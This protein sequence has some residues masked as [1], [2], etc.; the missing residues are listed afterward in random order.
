MFRVILFLIV[1]CFT[2]FI[3][4]QNVAVSGALVG[5]G[6][7]PTLT[8]AFAALNGGA[9]TGATITVSILANT[10]EGSGTAVLNAGAWT[11]ITVVPVGGPR[12]ITGA[13]A[14]G[15]PLIDLNGADR[16]T[17][18]GQLAGGVR[19]LT[20]ENTTVA[21]STGTSTVRLRNDATLNT[22]T[23]CNVLGGS[24]GAGATIYFAAG[25][26]TVGNDNN[27]I[28]LCDIG[29][30]GANLPRTAIFSLGDPS[31]AN[32]NNLVTQ[33][34]I[35]DYFQCGTSSTG[36]SLGE[37]NLAWTISQCRFY[38]TAPRVCSLFVW[39]RGILIDGSQGNADHTIT[40]NTFGYANSLGTGKSVF[41]SSSTSNAGNFYR[42]IDVPSMQ[43][44]SFLTVTNNVVA[45]L[46]FPNMNGNDRVFS[47]AGIKVRGAITIT[48]NTIGSSSVPGTISMGSLGGNGTVIGIDV[49]I[50]GVNS[51]GAAVHNNVV[52]GINL[53]V[54]TSST[55]SFSAI[56]TYGN[57]PIFYCN[58][59]S[60]QIGF[61]AAPIVVNS[62]SPGS[63]VRGI[64]MYGYDIDV[65]DN[66]VCYLFSRSVYSEGLIGLDIRANGLGNWLNRNVVFALETTHPT[67]I[68]R[69]IGILA[70]NMEFTDRNH[71]HSLSAASPNGNIWGMYVRAL[72]SCTYSNNM[73]RLG[74]NHQGQS[75]Q[76]GIR[77]IGIYDNFGNNDFYYNSVH[78]G[79]DN[80][81]GS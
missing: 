35:Y 49:E 80:V 2:P 3:H 28:S 45:G 64:E 66:R 14:P 73:V 12:S 60:N 8:A 72:D 23:Y 26:V 55:V 63:L 51:I 76:N 16:V 78:I 21:N 1:L 17:F 62:A 77:I 40:A 52:G 75:L 36:I 44:P 15:Q 27:T 70:F 38:Q 6:S 71:V 53:D 32:S 31:S 10:T 47:F 57:Q 20:L 79:G 22:I 50:T 65:F 34:N 61:A 41:A 24:T 56:K 5:N 11:S 33:C 37:G 39:H 25:Q 29:P 81:G 7:Y 9:Q 48:G 67:A 58:V 68:T 54:A 4:A 69:V 74:R 46:D 43:D 19:G 18:N 13:T 59:T 30:S 42:A